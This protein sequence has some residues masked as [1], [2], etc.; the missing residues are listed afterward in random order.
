MWR[1]I[2]GGAPIIV[3]VIAAP[4]GSDPDRSLPPLPRDPLLWTTVLLSLAVC[5]PFFR[6]VFWLGDEGVVLHGA[7]RILRGEA[8][9]REF[10]EFL[11]PGSFLIVAAWMHVVGPDLASVRALLVGLIAAIAAMTYIGGWLVSGNRPLAALL[12][13]AWAAFSQ[14][15]WTVINHHWFATAASMASAVSLLAGLGGARGRAA[16][17]GAG[18]FAGTAAMIVSTRGA[19]LCLAV[20]GVVLVLRDRRGLVAVAAGIAVFPAA[21]L[22]YLALTGAVTAAV[23]DVVLFPARHYSAIQGVAFGAST[24]LHQMPATAFFPLTFVLAGAAAAVDRS[25]L[26][27]EPRFVAS[28]ALALVGLLGAFP[29]PD[30]THINFTVPLA[31][32]LFGLVATRLFRRLGRAR[33]TVGVLLAVACAAAVGYRLWSEALPM[34]LGPLR[35][36][37]TAR[38]VFVGPPSPWIDAVAALVPHVQ[39]APGDDPYFFYPYS[40][41]LPYLTARRH[42]APLDVMVPGYTTPAQYHEVCR[43]VVREAR[44]VVLDRTWSHPDVL[45]AFFPSMRDP[46]PP[47]KRALE[48]ALDAAF[49][50][51]VHAWR[52]MELRGRGALPPEAVCG[53]PTGSA[54]P[55]TP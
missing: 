38:G 5:A 36:V 12:A 51:V 6:Y 27:H 50:R 7:E 15:G 33:V 29:R 24:P 49:D 19:L 43:R 9:Y 3:Q 26:W 35:Q 17:F 14:G 55:G 37:A 23:A 42:V 39:R 1:G 2:R 53:E 18:L 25:G 4:A 11:P 46:E 32:P 28:L 8:L 30:V 34:T 47:E 41:M 52:G 13:V 21:T 22:F 40:P 54:R 16:L 44:W 10:F 20:L 45:R 48:A 31:C